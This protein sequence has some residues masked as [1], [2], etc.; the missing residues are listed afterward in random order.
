MGKKEKQKKRHKGSYT[1]A[2]EKE[3]KAFSHLPTIYGR[4]RSGLEYIKNLKL[5]SLKAYF[6]K[7][8]FVGSARKMAPKKR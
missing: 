4:R 7:S 3:R 6:S 5:T 2:Y 1:K 8:P